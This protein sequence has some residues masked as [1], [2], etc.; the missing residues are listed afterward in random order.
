MRAPPTTAAVSASVQG[1]NAVMV[2]LGRVVAKAF[3][4]KHL[5]QD[6]YGYLRNAIVDLVH[7]ATNVGGARPVPVI[8]GVCRVAATAPSPARMAPS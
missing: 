2:N 8:T 7:T 4:P 6:F 3:D 1:V 5:N